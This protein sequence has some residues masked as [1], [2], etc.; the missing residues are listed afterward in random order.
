MKAR[1][2]GSLL[3]ILVVCGLAVVFEKDSS[4]SVP[5]VSQP[6]NNDAALKALSL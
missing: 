4:P 1:I 6:A 2:I 5:S 3:V